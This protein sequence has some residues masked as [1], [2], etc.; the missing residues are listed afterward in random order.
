MVLVLSSSLYAGVG[1]PMLAG[2]TGYFAY[3]DT[4]KSGQKQTKN[5]QDEQP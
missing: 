1:S 2:H 4:H 3:Q 5:T